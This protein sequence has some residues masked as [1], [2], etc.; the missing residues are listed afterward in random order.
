MH[1]RR[2][3]LGV[4]DKMAY[5]VYVGYSVASSKGSSWQVYLATVQ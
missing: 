5:L 2:P 4:Y 1:G 3:L